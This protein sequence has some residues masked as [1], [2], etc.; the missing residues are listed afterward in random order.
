LKAEHLVRYDG[1]QDFPAYNFF[2][3]DIGMAHAQRAQAMAWLARLWLVLMLIMLLAGSG[4]VARRTPDYPGKAGLR[5]V[6]QALTAPWKS[7]EAFDVRTADWLTGV[8]LPFVLI[9][10]CY[11]TFSSF[12]SLQYALLTLVM[13]GVFVV[14]LLLLNWRKPR[15]FW[16]A[17]LAASLL[18][19]TALLM[20]TAAVRGPGFFWFN[21]W[22]NPAGRTIFV[23]LDVAAILWMFFVLYAVQRATFGRSVLRTLGNLLLALGATFVA[24]G[25]VPALAGLEKTLTAIN[26]Q[27]AV[28]PLGLSRILG[29]TVHLGIPLELP[30]YM[31]AVGA[32][33]LGAGAL[34]L[35]LSMWSGRQRRAILSPGF[36]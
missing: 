6:W 18:L 15:L 25:V 14:S 17:T 32:F 19:P 33:L 16:L 1:D 24:L 23:S 10:L 9:A 29:I 4:A 11:L 36:D 31:M 3:A 27:M 20:L 7:H 13:L 12:L 28:L 34:M 5:A 22:T 21:F 35:A 26:D 8:S 30:T 2:S